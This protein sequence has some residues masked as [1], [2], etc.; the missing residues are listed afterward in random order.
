MARKPK[1]KTI[2][3][4]PLETIIEVVA[5]KEG[6]TPIVKE[7]TFGEALKMKKGR[8]WNYSNYQK[9]FYQNKNA[10]RK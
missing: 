7:M 1:G 5:T 10:I 8:G 4:L 2:I 6:E 3:Q 9:G